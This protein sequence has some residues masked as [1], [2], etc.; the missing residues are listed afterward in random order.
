MTASD[1]RWL[2]ESARERERRLA[3]RLLSIALGAS[4]GA[5]ACSAETP[6][7]ETSSV[8]S[9]A[10]SVLP[11]T[12]PEPTA[13][14]PAPSS[15]TASAP[16]AEPAQSGC[17]T[18]F[19][20]MKSVGTGEPGPKPAASAFDKNG[21]LPKEN[22]G[23]GCCV[24][25]SGG[26]KFV[27]DNCCY[28]FVE[29]P[30]C[31]RPFLVRGAPRVAGVQPG[32]GWT[33]ARTA[34]LVGFEDLPLDEATRAGGAQAWI[35]AG[36]MEHASV[37][38]FWQFGLQLLALGAPAELIA[39]TALAAQ[40]EVRHAEL[41][42]ALAA[43]LGRA[44]EPVALPTGGAIA[45]GLSE[46]VRAA[47]FE[48]CVGETVAA[49]TASYQAHLAEDWVIR[50]VL[51]E[52]AEDEARHAELSW[53]FVRWAIDVH[54]ERARAAAEGAFAELFAAHECVADGEIGTPAVLPL[55][56]LGCATP[57]E[58]R[59]LRDHVLL[60]VVGP[61]ARAICGRR[62]NGATVLST[63]QQEDAHG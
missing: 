49:V 3:S 34:A 61:C 29:G 8:S 7:E 28:S 60:E 40:D 31:G 53:Q 16:P 13:A 37:A 58:H 14:P 55:R 24:A 21:C 36:L 47:I 42:F 45:T 30:C 41:C 10:T 4:V 46:I 57:E 20:T 59:R 11:R 6:Q 27:N 15:V 51:E 63:K 5:A 54:G 19:S 38:S 23:N 62:P 9:T 17:F 12:V 22:V 50:G 25:A 39:S 44:A 33:D 26:P 48:G 52:I 56:R 1:S 35:E 18:P 2:G 43:R 32:S